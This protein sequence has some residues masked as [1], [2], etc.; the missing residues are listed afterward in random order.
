MRDSTRA[1]ID[2]SAEFGGKDVAAAVPPHFRALKK[3][4]RELVMAEFPF[5]KLA[6]ILRVDGEVNQYELSGAGHLEVDPNG[7]YLSVDI[8]IQREDR[9]RIVTRICD[10]MVSSGEQIREICKYQRWPLAT[11]VLML[12]LF[13]LIDRDKNEVLSNFA[14]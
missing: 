11:D 7:G 5:A 4:S 9:E 2:F 6:F 3:A 14:K 10:S 13:N 1:S 8:G 12:C